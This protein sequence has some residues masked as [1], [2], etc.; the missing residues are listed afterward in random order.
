LF[1]HDVAAAKADAENAAVLASAAAQSVLASFAGK[2][3][4]ETGA[5]SAERFKALVNEVK[6]ETGVK[7]KELFHPIRIALTGSHSGPEFDKIVPLME[8]GSGLGV[9][10]GVRE[11]VTNFVSE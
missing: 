10:P 11:R 4:A 3:A 6:A 2:V 8:E 9:V 5:I 7:G 1:T